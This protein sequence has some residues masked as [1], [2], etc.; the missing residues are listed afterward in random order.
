MSVSRAFGRFFPARPHLLV[1]GGEA[2]EIETVRRQ[3]D[4]AFVAVEKSQVIQKYFARVQIQGVDRDGIKASVASVV[5][6]TT[7]VAADFD[8]ILAPSTEVATINTPKQPTLFVSGSGTPADWLGGNVTFIGTARDGTALTETV[9]SAAGA[10]TTTCVNFFATVS[11]VA[12]PACGGTGALIEIGVA[13]D[14]SCI[15]SLATTTDAQLL[16][17]NGEF[18]RLR[19]G[20]RAL[21]YGRR[22]SFV[23]SNSVSW[24]AGNL[25]IKYLDVLG[26]ARTGTIAIPNGGNGTV[27]TAFFIKQ[28]VSF[29]F[30]AQGGTAGT[31]TVGILDTELGLEA[32]PIS[33]VEAVAVMREATQ[34]TTG[35]WAVP[36]AGVVDPASV[37]NAAPYG[38]YIP[39][40]A[41]AP[42]G[43]RSALLVY[44][45][46]P[47]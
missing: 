47:A 32:D 31:C 17:T 13:A 45:P 6:P 27:N 2:N 26:I 34:P 28:V 16:D 20:N 9:V 40:A 44:L 42:D 4:Q 11:S 29:S 46:N 18:N 24:L 35:I 3:V 43:I 33:D 15:V 37:A 23:F 19:V 12:L 36:A 5:A 22:L 8:G 39:T 7:Y 14:L 30:G 25:T 38:R 21:Q 10:G 1:G 41:A